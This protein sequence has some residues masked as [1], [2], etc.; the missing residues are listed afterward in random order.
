MISLYFNFYY[1]KDINECL[2]NKFI[3]GPHSECTNQYGSYSCS[4]QPGFIAN[5][6]ESF[7]CEDFNECSSDCSND[8]D[9]EHATCINLIGSFECICHQGFFG[10]GKLHQCHD[11]N[12]CK[13][14][15]SWANP[16]K[17]QC[18]DNA[19]CLNT[20]GG[21]ECH[22]QEGFSGNGTFCEDI[23]ECIDLGRE[24]ECQEKNSRCVNTIGSYECKCLEGYFIDLVSGK[25]VDIDECKELVSACEGNSVCQNLLGSY[26]CQCDLGFSWSVTKRLCEDINEC[27]IGGDKLL[28]ADVCDNHSICVN[29]VGSFRCECKYGWERVGNSDY[30][31]GK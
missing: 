27:V 7:H 3:C 17:A 29:T 5:N 1:L 11:I 30:C 22:C 26:M 12:E 19:L 8:C 16:I 10:N 23:N 20:I 14:M 21:F 2:L 15:S 28:A 9:P 24:K 13:D 25:C 18:S 31:S 6:G 4:C